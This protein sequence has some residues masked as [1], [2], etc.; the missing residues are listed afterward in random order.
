VEIVN[1][2]VDHIN[3]N[4]QLAFSLWLGDLTQDSTHDEMILA[5]LAL[6]RL[7][8]P[9]YVLRGNH[10]RSGGWFEKE[11]GSLRQR[12]E[13]GGWVF[14]LADSNPGDKT[15]MSQTDRDWLRKQLETID[16]KTPI[17]LC[18]H[19]PLMP[20]TRAYHLAGADE[21][22]ALFAGHNLK[23]CLSG[24]YH[25][26]QEEIVNGILFTTTACLATTR[27]NFDGT[28]ARGYRIFECRN[29]DITTRFVP[30]RD[31]PRQK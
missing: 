20:H 10:D 19:H 14:L 25:G 17:V 2:A 24:H 31:I 13:Y 21:V 26:N 16:P 3:A 18:T 23:A 11:F 4:P 9:A 27:N 5:R 15:P 12:F 30:V 6:S 28:T 22:V 1:D 7:K 8:K 29:G